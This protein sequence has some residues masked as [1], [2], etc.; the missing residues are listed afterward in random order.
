MEHQEAIKMI[1]EAKKFF[2]L[3]N[4]IFLIVLL[5]EGPPIE[6]VLISRWLA[7]SSGASRVWKAREEFSREGNKCCAWKIRDRVA[8]DKRTANLKFS[9]PPYSTSSQRRTLDH[10]HR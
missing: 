5:P 3:T 10:Y 1:L 2:Y 8:P 6:T 7:A 9:I 4:E